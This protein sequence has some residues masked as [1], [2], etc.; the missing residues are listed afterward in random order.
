MPASALTEN[1]HQT[2]A[3]HGGVLVDRFVPETER[4]N[5][6]ARAAGLAKI[7]LNARQISDLEL[8]AIGAVSP[9]IGFMSQED[10]KSVVQTMHLANGVPWSIPVT[11]AVTPE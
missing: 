7:A 10:Y 5:V 1:T 3:P 4:A 6:A 2:I 11:L 9:L 8:I